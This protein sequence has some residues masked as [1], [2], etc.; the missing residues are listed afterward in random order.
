MTPLFADLPDV[1]LGPLAGRPDADWY[2]APPGKWCPAQI[3]EHLAI[4]LDSSSRRFEERR[5]RE[6]M[7]R[8]PRSPL[9]RIAYFFIMR[10]GWVPGVFNAPEGTRPSDRPDR[11]AAERRF[12]E[13]VAR[14]QE[15]ERILLPARRNDLFVKHPVLGDLNFEEWLHFHV[16]HCGHHAKQIRERLPA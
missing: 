15:L 6:P 3:V 4:G 12:R 9:A 7:V 5:A 11:A 13:G 14:F 16:W 8:R 10:L 2:H 1:V